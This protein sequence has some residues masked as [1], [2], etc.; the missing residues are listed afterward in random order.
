M[1]AA[2]LW[3]QLEM[4]D[5]IDKKRHAIY[6]YYDAALKPL[7]EAGYIEQPFVPDYATHNAH[8]YFIKAKD[9]EE[10]TKLLNY[11]R[12]KGVWGVFHYI[13]LH[14]ATAGRKF[15]RFH[16][17]D[18]YT[19]KESERIMRLPMFY[20]LDMKDVEYVAQCILDYPAFNR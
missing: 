18:I 3:A 16:G 9:L 1:N 4:A 15:G 10:R 6:D 12:E 7:A 19:T 8:M 14:S 20:N 2:Y 11:L 5:E 17:E 13:P